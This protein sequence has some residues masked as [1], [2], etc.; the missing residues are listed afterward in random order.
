MLD[1][2]FTDKL[3]KEMNEVMVLKPKETK[4][5]MT[6]NNIVVSIHGYQTT[7]NL[8]NRSGYWVMAMFVIE[9]KYHEV[10]YREHFEDYEGHGVNVFTK[11]KKIDDFKYDRNFGESSRTHYGD[12]KKINV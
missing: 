12:I 8:F 7:H 9:D 6:V 2:D 4:R 1:K 3:V 11:W 10:L 5:Q